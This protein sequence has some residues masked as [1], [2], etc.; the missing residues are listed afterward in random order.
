MVLDTDSRIEITEQEF[1][2][3]KR[4]VHQL[5]NVLEVEDK[6][7]IAL[8][9]YLEFETTILEETARDAIFS[10]FK[11]DIQFQEL[12]RLIARRLSNFMSSGRLYLD[13]LQHHSGAILSEDSS[14]LIIVQSAASVEYD[15]SL[16][17]RIVE[18]LRN[19]AQH[20]SLPVHGLSL[21]H[22]KED[23]RFN[24]S[25]EPTL[26]CSQLKEDGKFKAA[27]LKEF[28]DDDLIPLKPTIKSYIESLGTIHRKFRDAVASVVKEA[29]DDMENAQKTFQKQFPDEG[30]IAFAA[31]PVD[32]EGFKDGEPLY[33]GDQLKTHFDY[34][35]RKWST[36]VNFSRR[37]VVY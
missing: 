10:S 26:S 28:S 18:A 5:L 3:L 11:T 27:I 14:K 9:N 2:S 13:A 33:L 29:M 22:W 6:F 24:F 35:H 25:I 30:L 16:N 19:Y 37:K 15:T 36:M 12:K 17:Y 32:A 23:K 4:A 8:E 7:D 1:L 31:L 21:N 20:R 34:F